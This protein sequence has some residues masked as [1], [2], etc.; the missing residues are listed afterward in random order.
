MVVEPLQKMLQLQF[1][2]NDLNHAGTSEED[3]L[4]EREVPPLVYNLR[5][6]LTQQAGG[7][8]NQVLQE[9]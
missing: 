4:T 1:N 6:V 8:K 5:K 3:P 7:R 2:S 9:K